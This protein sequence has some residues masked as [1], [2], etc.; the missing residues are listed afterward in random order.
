MG[1]F[2]NADDG[3]YWTAATTV[4]AAAICFLVHTAVTSDTEAV[5]MSKMGYEEKVEIY[6]YS[7]HKYPTVIKHWVKTGNCT[8]GTSNE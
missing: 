6:Y 5:K 8:E 7:E 1:F 2:K 3:V 4:V